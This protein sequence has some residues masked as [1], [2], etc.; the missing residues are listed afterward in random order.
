MDISSA[1]L[2][3][4]KINQEGISI[5]DGKCHRDY[6]LVDIPAEAWY[7]PLDDFSRTYLAPLVGRS[8]SAKTLHQLLT[9][10]IDVL[11]EIR[12]RLGER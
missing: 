11:A 10:A 9:T 4:Y 8:G 3:A 7:L 6:Y 2:N 12:N 5:F 1:M